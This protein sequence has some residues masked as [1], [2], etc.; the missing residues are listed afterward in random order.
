MNDKQ[1][2]YV[3]TDT[4]TAVVPSPSPLVA[5]GT[6]DL[7]RTMLIGAGV[8][9]ATTAL[10][11]V[12]NTYLFGAALCRAGVDGCENAPLY[13]AI[14]ALIVGVIAGIVALAKA[15]AY[16]PLLIAIAAAAALGGAFGFMGQS[17]WYGALLIG[18]VLFALAYGL[19]A[20][21]ARLRSFVLS[22]LLLVVV[23]A[24]VRLVIA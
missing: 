6:G 3:K 1:K 22:L 11:L 10:Y 8:G 24:L 23:A 4:P 13:S 19:F 18:A 12:L 9:L 20:W 15:G 17:V 21:L 5:M 14:V 2:M 16:R 7:I